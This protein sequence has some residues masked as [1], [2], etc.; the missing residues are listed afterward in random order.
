MKRTRKLRKALT[1]VCCAL[2]L[3]ALSVGAT[4]AYLTSTPATVKNTFAVGKVV[5]DLDE[6]KVK[7]FVSTAANN[8][9]HG[10]HVENYLNPE[11]RVKANVYKLFPA[12]TYDKD[13]I[14]HVDPASEVCYLFV[15]VENGLEDYESD[16]DGYT[17]IEQQIKDNNWKPLG[18]AYPNVFWKIYN[19]NSTTEHETLLNQPVFERF[20]IDADLDATGLEEAAD[21]EINITAYAIQ[22]DTIG[23]A[24]T[25]WNILNPPTTEGEGED[26]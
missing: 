23:D 7:E 8:E 26:A 25:A 12:Y 1:L 17:T 5:I 11:N 13:P 4:V 18:D 19:P 22:K 2:L 6:G 16:A 20:T 15:K 14:V 21:A 9:G 24:A 3:V 10:K